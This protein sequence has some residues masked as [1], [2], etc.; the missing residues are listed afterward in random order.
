MKWKI[1]FPNCYNKTLLCK[2]FP[3]L[4]TDITCLEQIQ[5]RA[6]KFILSDNFLGNKSRFHSLHLLPLMH[7]LEFLDVMFLVKCLKNPQDNPDICSLVTFV[8]SCTSAS[9][10]T[11][12]QHNFC[13]LLVHHQTLLFQQN[14]A[15]VE[16][17]ASCWHFTIISHHPAT[18]FELFLDSFNNG[19][20]C[21]YFLHLSYC[22][23][24]C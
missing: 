16:R 21:W 20:Q 10:T 14:S 12:M 3:A 2:D 6:T 11:K 9:T 15:V 24:L 8:K 4:E 22:R 5:R 23:P 17:H 13:H 7:W 18:S 1:F 19:L